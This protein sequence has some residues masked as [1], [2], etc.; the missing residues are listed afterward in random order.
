MGSV[1]LRKDTGSWVI[2]YKDIRGKWRIKSVGKKP[3]ATKTMAQKVLTEIERKVRLG[4][5]DM[6]DAKIPTL[7]EITP[8]YINYQINKQKRS[9]RDDQR[10]LRDFNKVFGNL[11]LSQINSRDIDEYKNKRLNEVKPASVNRELS[12]L[13]HLFNVAKR[14]KQFFGENPVAEAG[15]LP[16]NNQVERILTN[17]E[18]EILLKV[19]PNYL[20]NIIICAL[21]TAMRIG[22]IIT[23]KWDNIN[24]DSNTITIEQIN[25][26]NK[27]T[28]KIPINSKLRKL[29][30]ELK[31]RSS[32]CEYV[33]LNSDN[34]PYKKPDSLNNVYR[35]ALNKCGI[36]GLRFHD[37]RHTAATRMIENGASI[38]AVNK[39]LRH[40]DLRTTMRYMH[41]DNSL[42]DAVETLAKKQYLESN[43]NVFGNVEGN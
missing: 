11:K 28:Q 4:Q 27:K 39:I 38:V 24:F 15:L 26:K 40:A 12:T 9:I 22:E 10:H 14:W 43:G 3:A 17:E 42:V 36:E 7:K 20:K 37:L 30:L 18:E 31:L 13:R 6:I 2:K 32:I 29:F 23:L 34:R 5:H 21:N 16:V 25:S 35:N 33:F 41:P 8:T 1:F 19:S